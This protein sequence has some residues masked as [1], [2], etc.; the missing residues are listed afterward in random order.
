MLR[1]LIFRFWPVWIPLVIYLIWFEIVRRRAIKAGLPVPLFREGP[2]YWAVL[3]SLLIAV[4]CFI[5][6]GLSNEAHKGAYVPPHMENGT[7]IPGHV[8]EAP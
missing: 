2:W 3:S 6:L 1:F 7:L 8:D 5:A 4:A